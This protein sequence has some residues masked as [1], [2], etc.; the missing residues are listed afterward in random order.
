[1]A[2]RVGILPQECGGNVMRAKGWRIKDLARRA[3]ARLVELLEGTSYD[4]LAARVVSWCVRVGR[5]SALVDGRRAGAVG[6]PRLEYGERILERA[7]QLDAEYFCA[8]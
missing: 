1:M 7:G 8:R 2:H 4:S 6:Q 5:R 3:Q